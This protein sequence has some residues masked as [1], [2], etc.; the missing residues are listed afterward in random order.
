MNLILPLLLCPA[1]FAGAEDSFLL[2]GATVHPVTSEDIP[3]GSVLALDG[4]IAQTGVKVTAPKDVRAI[5]AKNL[6]VWPG[7]I[8]SATHLGLQEITS[9]A[10]TRDSAEVG[11]FNPQLRAVAAVNPASEH[12]PV[13]RAN[14]ITSVVTMPD[15]G[16]IGG[17]AALVHLDG[18]TWEEMAILRSAALC[19]RFPRTMTS[20]QGSAGGPPR[21]VPFA[22]A[23]RNYVKNLQ[24]LGEFF[25]QARRYQCA[26]TGGNAGFTE[27]LKLEAMLPVLDG[28]TPVLVT[29]V[30]EREILAA[31]DFAARQKVRIILAGVRG[32][33]K[34]L[35][36][37]AA[38]KVPVILGKTQEL[39]LEQDDPYDAVYMLPV[40][41]HKAGVKFA[42]GHFDVQLAPNLPYQPASSVAFGLPREQALRAV[43][44]NAAEIW[45]VADRPGSIE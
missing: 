1:L 18:W 30:H 37:L 22:E 32:P 33:G 44:I 31:L 28:K 34:S 11:S 40:E 3:N 25:E 41:L 16:V 6:H 10:E 42:F 23:R 17:L 4:K 14:G 7:M 27:N 9:V 5:D 35:E 19:L 38:E 43:T 26:K 15:G 2:R 29:A 20:V 12:I 21:R 39:P 24:E 36:R 13:V 45:G 8:N